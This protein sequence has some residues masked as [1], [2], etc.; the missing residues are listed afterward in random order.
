MSSL[1]TGAYD[2]AAFRIAR[3]LNNEDLFYG[4]NE[5]FPNF[6]GL[7]FIK[8]PLATSPSFSHE[9]LK[10]CLHY[11]IHTIYPIKIEEILELS[12][13]ITL[14]EE[15]DIK[16]ISPSINYINSKSF[17]LIVKLPNL[18]II[19]NGAY[20]AGNKPPIEIISSIQEN[21]GIFE[22]DFINNELVFN[23]FSI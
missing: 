5:D 10:I 21:N 7:S 9:F 3:F 4:V 13:A 16:I 2:A 12:K 8:I 15:F 6:S 22:W 18:V 19:K 14:F 23:L 1:I 17:N 11:Q 20:F